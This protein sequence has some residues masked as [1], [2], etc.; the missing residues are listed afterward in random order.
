[1]NQDTTPPLP[2]SARFTDKQ[3]ADSLNVSTETVR[4][5]IVRY[6]LRG[7]V[8]IGN[9]VIIIDAAAFY[10]SMPDFHSIGTPEVN[11]KRDKLPER[12]QRDRPTARKA[13]A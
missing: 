4:D 5:W 12:V 8:K 13:S 1:M 10:G 6:K 9:Q 11:P 3:F 7:A 2:A